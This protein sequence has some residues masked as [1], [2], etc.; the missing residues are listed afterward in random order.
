MHIYEVQLGTLHCIHSVT[1]VTL[2]T[3]FNAICWK[4]K[5]VDKL[6]QQVHNQC[7]LAEGSTKSKIACQ[8]LRS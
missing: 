5:V 8:C 2:Q 1:I 4:V 6:D 3:S 7:H